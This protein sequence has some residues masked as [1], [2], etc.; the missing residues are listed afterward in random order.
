MPQTTKVTSATLTVSDALAHWIIM[1]CDCPVRGGC[2]TLCLDE[3]VE[4]FEI[5]S[6]DVLQY[7]SEECLKVLQ[8]A[9]GNQHAD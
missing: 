1:K 5:A 9:E 8:E 6:G 7:C 2:G 3:E 4:P